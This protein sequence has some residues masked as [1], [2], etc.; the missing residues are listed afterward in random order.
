VLKGSKV[1]LRPMKQDD[2]A[3]QHAFDQDLELYGLDCVPPRVSPLETAQAFYETRTKPDPNLAPFAIEADGKYI[4]YCGLMNVQDRHGNLE[5][6]ILL[7]R[8][9]N[10]ASALDRVPKRRRAE[11][12][13]A[14]YK[15]L[16]MKCYILRVRAYFREGASRPSSMA[17]ERPPQNSPVP[18]PQ[19]GHRRWPQRLSSISGWTGGRVA[20]C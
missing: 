17:S 13:S 7:P 14:P 6:G 4:G 16:H 18:W 10:V 15:V 12:E 1:L 20:G 9:R 5:L 11:G 19:N 2:I 8:P 3:R